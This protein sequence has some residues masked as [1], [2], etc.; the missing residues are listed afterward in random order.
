M[1]TP[2]LRGFVDDVALGEHQRDEHGHSGYVVAIYPNRAQREGLETT[3]VAYKGNSLMKLFGPFVAT[4]LAME[5]IKQ[6][7]TKYPLSRDCIS[8]KTLSNPHMKRS[9]T[10][11]INFNLDSP[12]E[13]IPEKRRRP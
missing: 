5:F 10:I 2:T 13:A 6:Y 3:F 1:C 8:V 7:E 4:S 11:D 9:V 12:Y